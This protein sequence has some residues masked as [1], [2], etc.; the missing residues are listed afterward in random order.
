MSKKDKQN[1]QENSRDEHINIETLFQKF[2]NELTIEKIVQIE[3]KNLNSQYE[4]LEKQIQENTNILQELIDQQKIYDANLEEK[5]KLDKKLEELEKELIN[6]KQEDIKEFN[7]FKKDISKKTKSLVLCDQ[8][9]AIEKRQKLLVEL[10]NQ[11]QEVNL[12]L[13]KNDRISVLLE[14]CI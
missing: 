7:K 3:R 14:I 8:Q 11:L 2:I 6:V 13:G 9:E 12:K 10:E 4:T 5:Q 1:K